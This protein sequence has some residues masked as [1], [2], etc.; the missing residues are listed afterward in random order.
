MKKLASE[1]GIT[2]ASFHGEA[3]H[4]RG[5]IDAICSFGCKMQL[6]HKIATNDFWF[7]YASQMVEYLKQYFKD[8][9]TKEYAM[10]DAASSAKI[11]KNKMNLFWNHVEYF[12]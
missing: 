2:I 11:R 8:S 4:G 7:E 9:I 1:F 5:L 3:G 12:I 10:I 6:Q